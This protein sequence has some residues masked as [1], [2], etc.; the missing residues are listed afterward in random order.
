M[1]YRTTMYFVSSALFFGCA[2]APQF[3]GNSVTDQ[4]LRNDVMKHVNLLFKVQ[5][6]CSSISNVQTKVTNLNKSSTGKIISANELWT[7]NGCEKSVN[8][9]IRLKSDAKGETDFSVSRSKLQP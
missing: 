9:D 1:N 8:Y 5:E 2:T 4:T 7:A 3:S 6:S